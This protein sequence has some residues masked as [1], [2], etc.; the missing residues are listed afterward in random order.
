M[1]IIILYFNQVKILK[2]T[3]EYIE[4]S[5]CIPLGA[6]SSAKVHKRPLTNA[7]GN[8]NNSEAANVSE[9]SHILFTQILLV[10]ISKYINLND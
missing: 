5:A 3:A 7:D 10:F 2:K 1:Y 8:N 4:K 9:F 6:G